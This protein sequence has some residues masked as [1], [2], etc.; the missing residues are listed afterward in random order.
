MTNNINVDEI[1]ESGRGL[2]LMWLLTDELNY[3]HTPAQQNC[4]LLVN[5]SEKRSCSVTGIKSR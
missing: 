5:L 4:L 2:Q 3:T 1:P